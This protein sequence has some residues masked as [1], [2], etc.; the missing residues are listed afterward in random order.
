[1]L[2]HPENAVNAREEKFREIATN[3]IVFQSEACPS[4][5]T[6]KPPSARPSSPPAGHRNPSS[7]ITSKSICG[8][9]CTILFYGSPFLKN[10]INTTHKIGMIFSLFTLIFLSSFNFSLFAFHFSLF[11]RIFVAHC[12]CYLFRSD[13]LVAKRSLR[14]ILSANNNS[15]SSYSACL[16]CES[17]RNERNDK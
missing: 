3:A 12:G 5:P 2:N 10:R 7:T 1:M 16:K 17:F 8:E 14:T 4:Q 15:I 6:S 11:F 9:K 13:E